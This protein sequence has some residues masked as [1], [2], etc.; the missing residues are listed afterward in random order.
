MRKPVSIVGVLN[1]TPDSFFAGSRVTPATVAMQAVTMLREGAD[2]LE[3]G[4]ESTGPSSRDVTAEEE[5]ARV[6]PVIEAVKKAKADAVIAVDT[7]KSSVALAA[8]AAGAALINDVTA[9]RR[10]PALFECVASSKAS[11]VLMY[12]K[13]ASPRTTIADRRYDDVIAEVKSF[14]EARV[15][16]A[17]RAGI[18]CGRIIIDPGLGHF[19][20]SDPFYS[21]EILNRLPEL[22]GLGPVLVSPSRKSFLA[23]PEGLPASERLPATLAASALAVVRGASFIRTHDVL[24]T[25]Q[26]IEAVTVLRPV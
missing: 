15:D 11:I 1:A 3:I 8:I 20:S 9:G 25:K 6:L 16:A 14:L 18:P 13:D 5:L 22:T 12:S 23:G 19:V 10:D 26:T 24:R 7:W 17:G 4:G 2:I 21:Y